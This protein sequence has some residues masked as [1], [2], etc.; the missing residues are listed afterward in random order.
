MP[1]SNFEK[2]YEMIKGSVWYS[3]RCVSLKIYKVVRIAILPLHN[4]F[5]EFNSYHLNLSK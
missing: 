2:I 4:I 3:V 5:K 1:T